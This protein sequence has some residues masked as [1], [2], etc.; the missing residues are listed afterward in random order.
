MCLNGII[1]GNVTCFWNAF[2]KPGAKIG[3]AFHMKENCSY[4]HRASC[5]QSPHCA[6]V[7]PCKVLLLDFY[8]LYGTFIQTTGQLPL[9]AALNNQLNFSSMHNVVTLIQY[10]SNFSR[11]LEY[12]IISHWK[13]QLLS[14]IYVYE[15]CFSSLGKYRPVCM[16][17]CKGWVE[18]V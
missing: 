5:T 8:A 11:L 13:S 18:S 1:E 12:I 10:L 6:H 3:N 2:H 16:G 14:D 15:Y 4:A 7:I 9:H 17:W